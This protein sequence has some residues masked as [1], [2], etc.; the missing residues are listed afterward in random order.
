MPLLGTVGTASS[1]SYGGITSESVSASEDYFTSKGGG[2]IGTAI[3]V[4]P[5][6]DMN[7]TNS[8]FIIPNGKHPYGSFNIGPSGTPYRWNDW[9]HDVFDGWGHW[10]VGSQ[11]NSNLHSFIPFNTLNGPD[12]TVYT[13][14]GITLAGETFAYKHGWVGQGVFKL[15][16]TCTSSTNFQF[17]VGHYGD[18]GSDG[19]H[20]TG[21]NA[22]PNT[23]PGSTNRNL[24]WFTTSQSGSGTEVFSVY[25]IPKVIA[26][27]TGSW[28]ASRFYYGMQGSPQD[29]LHLW[30]DSITHGITFYYAK[31]TN[32][33]SQVQSDIETNQT[34]QV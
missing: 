2:N 15:D 7:A 24:Y 32:F 17:I 4:H 13:E 6:K 16:L 10:W 29:D 27:N 8:G 1:A 33:L 3:A 31:S 14:T 23:L 34:Y 22:S 30:V 26:Q 12:G 21:V 20:S 19:N 25:C 11:T 5:Y 28:N 18:M 9:G